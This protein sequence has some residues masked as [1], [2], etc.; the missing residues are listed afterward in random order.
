MIPAKHFWEKLNNLALSR[1]LLLFATGW[2]LVQLL[3]YF[4]TTIVI[5]TF[6][7]IIA[8]LLSYP[9]AWVRRFLPHHI[10]VSLV[11]LISFLTLI[12]FTF[13]LGLAILSQG[14]QLLDSVTSF[15][16]SIAPLIEELEK[17]LRERNLQIN[18]SAI[19]E[20]LKTQ[21]LAIIGGLIGTSQLLLTNFIHFILIAVVAFFMLLDGEK[22]W[23]FI[24]KL[25]PAQDRDNFTDIIQRNF[26]GFFKGQLILSLFFGSCTFILFIFLKIPFA[27]ILAVIAGIFEAI[28]GIGATMGISLIGL[29]LLAQSFWLAVEAVFGCFIIQQIKDNLVTP[30]VMQ[31]SLNINP[32]LIFFALLI[33]LRIAGLLGIFL[34]IPIAGV[35][36]SL[37]EIEDM[38]SVRA[39]KIGLTDIDDDL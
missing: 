6:A 22:L 37:F 25:V 23:Q 3:A 33:G 4:E 14:K 2:A 12:V 10:A 21:A 13:T 30:R 7:A 31:K 17:N 8:F 26:L 11:F 38:K 5:F 28:P 34:A 24:L 1:F 18:L 20:P 27:L 39:S 32:V 29:I 16:S 35:M 9:V 19:E 36:V 15:F